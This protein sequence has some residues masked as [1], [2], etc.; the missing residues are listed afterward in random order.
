MT[1]TVVDGGPDHARY[2]SFSESI[3]T[4]LK[5]PPP[6]DSPPKLTVLITS[7]R[8][9]SGFLEV[10]LSIG[11]ARGSAGHWLV[12]F[13]AKGAAKVRPGA[14]RRAA[15]T[16]AWVQYFMA[17]CRP[18]VL[19]VIGH[20]DVKLSYF[21]ESRL[22]VKLSSLRV[23]DRDFIAYISGGRCPPRLRRSF[24]NLIRTS[25]NGNHP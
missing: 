11:K 3:P 20:V 6:P 4:K 15:R 25:Q 13:A 22:A 2:M 12:E 5:S 10:L 18:T 17:A 14:A 23:P 8:A 19:V 7:R 9:N 21:A 16:A 1:S 24:R